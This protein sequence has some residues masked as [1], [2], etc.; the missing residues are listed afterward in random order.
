[1]FCWCEVQYRAA[2][3]RS[4][5]GTFATL[6][7]Q[8]RL[9]LGPKPL[10]QLWQL[11]PQQGLLALWQWLEAAN[12]CGPRLAFYR[13]LMTVYRRMPVSNTRDHSI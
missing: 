11:L 8:Y 5:L 13:A 7:A 4:S 1:M 3:Y 10:S 12:I 6:I 2:T 9:D